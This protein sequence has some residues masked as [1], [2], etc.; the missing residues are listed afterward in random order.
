MAEVT[1][2]NVMEL[3]RAIMIQ[4]L[5]EINHMLPPEYRAT[6]MIRDNVADRMVN[7]CGVDDTDALIECLIKQR[8]K[9]KNEREQTSIPADPARPLRPKG[10]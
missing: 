10:S 2:D 7:I 9:I 3:F 4:H 5:R 6:I 8:E 1:K